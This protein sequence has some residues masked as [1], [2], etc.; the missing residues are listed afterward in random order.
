MSILTLGG[1]Q[2]VRNGIQYDYCFKESIE[3]L[4]EFCDKVSVVDVGSSD[5]T[6]DVLKEL[7]SKH[8]NLIVTYLSNEDWER[9]QGEKHYKLCIFT[10]IAIRKLNTDYNYYQQSDEI[11]HEKSYDAIRKAIETG[12]EGFLITRVN[13]W[14]TPYH[15]LN[16][17]GNRHPC[18]PY[19]IRLAK[20]KYLSCGD[21]ESLDVP[22][23]NESFANE[24]RMYHMGFVRKR[25]VMKDKI[26]NMQEG[27]F[28][29]GS[30]DKKLD[31]SDIFIPERWFG[32]E[33]L[34]L[35]DEPLPKMIQR[36][37]KERVY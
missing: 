18:S 13:L 22:N 15:Q 23:V 1:S 31:G 12:F 30:H 5:G 20:T 11:T 21:A 34:K 29:L 4:L 24:I 16:V 35:I 14:E 10:D 9:T 32:K 37:A 27:V 33:D 6:V 17:Q 2:F 36:W 19:V 3:S 25:E 8:S 28:E 7:E 26:I